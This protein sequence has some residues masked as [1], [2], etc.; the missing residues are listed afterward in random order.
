MKLAVR[1]PVIL[2]AVFFCCCLLQAQKV[3]ITNDNGINTVLDQTAIS[4]LPHVTVS[5][6]GASATSFEGVALKDVLEKAGVG[7]GDLLKGK[8]LASCLLASGADGFQVVIA[9]PEL[10]PSFT[11]KKVMLAFLQNGRPLAAGDGPFR[12]VIPDDKRMSRWVKH[13]TTLKIVDAQ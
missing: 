5:T 3:T 7:F 12:I 1:T 2:S 10:D 9:L 8:R 6:G 13:V 4:A 11:D